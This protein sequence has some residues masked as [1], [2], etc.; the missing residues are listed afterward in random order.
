LDLEK[1]GGRSGARAYLEE[2]GVAAEELEALHGAGV[3]CDD[4]VVVIG[5]L[6]DDEVVGRLLP[7]EDRHRLVLLR[8]LPAGEPEPGEKNSTERS[9]AVGHIGSG[10]G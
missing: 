6:L 9:T 2:D 10:G 4:G 7:L 8:P 1:G 3:E 5:G